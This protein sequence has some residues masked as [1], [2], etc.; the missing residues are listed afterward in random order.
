M[1]LFAKTFSGLEETLCEE[2]KD[3]GAENIIPTKRGVSFEG[4]TYLM[5]AANYT[6]RTA[7]RILM[8]VHTFKAEN[9]D[10]LYN[11][12]R[13]ITWVDLFSVNKSFA[14]DSIV[15]SKH[16]NHSHFVSLKAKDAIADAFREKFNRR[17]NVE[18]DSK[19]F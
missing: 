8:P 14:I 7:V 3:L 19:D 6:A 5:Y 1:K 12:I 2:L 16:F 9:Q 18:N 13:E 11:G 15:S 4:D 10:E 17:P